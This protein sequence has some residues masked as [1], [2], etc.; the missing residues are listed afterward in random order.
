MFFASKRPLGVNTRSEHEDG[1][2]FVEAMNIDPKADFH[3][4]TM[5]EARNV[6]R[7]FPSAGSSWFGWGHACGIIN[8]ERRALILVEALE[9]EG[10]L[11]PSEGKDGIFQRTEVGNQFALASARTLKRATAARMLSNL[12]DRANGIN[13]NPYCYRVGALV[14][15]GSYLD[16]TRDRLGDLDVGYVMQRRYDHGSREAEEAESAS[17]DRAQAA[18]R[19]V[20]SYDEWLWWPE[21]EFLLALKGRTAG[22]SLHNYCGIDRRVIDGAPHRLVF[23]DASG[24]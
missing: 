13:A 6:V 5:L 9:R 19:R 23:G 7:R 12:I 2:A 18:G 8:D 15:F 20:S 11:V 16:E 17:R 1:V 10:Y 21:R 22:L 4:F 3:G 24:V 14:V